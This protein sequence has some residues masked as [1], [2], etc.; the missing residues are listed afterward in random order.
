MP[1]QT[2]PAVANPYIISF[3]QGALSE[4]FEEFA[5]NP[6]SRK[7]IRSYSNHID[8]LIMRLYLDAKQTGN[9]L[10]IL[11]VGGYGRGEMF[12]HSDV[13]IMFLVPANGSKAAEPVIN[14]ILY[15][16]W[17]LK[18]KVGHSVRTVNEALSESL[19]DM[20]TR[21]NLLEARRVAGSQALANQ[22]L[23]QFERKIVKGHEREFIEAKLIERAERHQKFGDSRALLEPN[24]KEGKG[25]LRDLQLLMWLMRACYNVKKMGEIEALGKIST[26][27]LKDFRRARKFL[28]LVRLHLH[29]IAG[30]AEERMSLDVQR[31]IAERLGYRGRHDANQSVERFMKRYFQVTRT[32]SQ[33][34]RTLCFLLEEEWGKQPRTGIKAL[35]KRQLLPEGLKIIS[36]RL[37]FETS[38]TVKEKPELIVGIFWFLHRL[39]ID[40]HPAA[41]QTIT[42][43]LKL[44][45]AAYRNQKHVNDY[46]LQ[47]LLDTNNPLPTLKRMNESG[48]LG[49]FIPEFGMLSGQMQFDLYHTYTVD[50]HILNAVGYLH[51]MEAGQ[52]A[53]SVPLA[54]GLFAQIKARRV[55]YLALLCHDIAKGRGGSHH[56]KGIQIGLRLAKQFGFDDAEMKAL[57][58]LIE[59]HQ[60]MSMVAFKRDLDDADTISD[61]AKKVQTVDQLNILY[62]MTIADIHAVANN[63][64]NSWKGDLLETLYHKTEH[65]LN[66][67]KSEVLEE[68]ASVID[69]KSSLE[70]KLPRV[71]P[72]DI[73]NYVDN[74]DTVSLE[75]YDVATHSRI[76]PCWY[77][78]KSGEEFGIRFKSYKRQ[79]ITQVTIAT[80]NRDG[81]FSQIS[82]VLAVCG[83]NIINARICTRYDD[84]VID[85]FAIQN[86]SGQLF[87]EERRQDKVKAKLHQV[88][89][90]DLD[91][92]KALLEAETRYPI[93][94]EVFAIKPQI[95]LDNNASQ[96]HSLVEIQC[97]DR[98]GLLY[99]VTKTIAQAQLV[100]STSHISTYGEKV[101]DVFY[102]QTRNEQK[103]SPESFEIL[104]EQLQHL[105]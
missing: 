18:L 35:W 4:I 6:S 32:V 63:I 70:A 2:S 47:L 31:Q 92:E 27:E 96:T 54:T 94:R 7:A 21:T 65:Q 20:K 85:R 58:W 104:R 87:A 53:D 61:F 46:F 105:L 23:E 14:A 59:H 72:R 5:A 40:I 16:L 68:V 88:L 3:H 17:D 66:E 10:S 37:H 73:H 49:K 64:W 43:N 78:V 67:T 69:L 39:E 98:R 74:A 13:D 75:G 12:F 34:T 101:V 81:L 41:W 97:I 55:M 25:G 9:V 44:I 36:N 15:T 91:L 30:R 52:M 28:H 24:V 48:V 60:T 99:Y 71:N 95:L 77:A 83:A 19:D 38:D 86:E 33:L 84:I 93:S 51:M 42:R 103:L 100:I 102:V 22:F 56:L 79:N 90:G 1:N 62:V 45:N 26:E 82:G 11:A 29:Q 80:A 76:F 50:E 8:K 57:A 89:S